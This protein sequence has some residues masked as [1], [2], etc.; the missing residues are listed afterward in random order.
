MKQD[1]DL[2]QQ[3]PRNDQN[4]I[5]IRLDQALVARGIVDTRAR[6]RDLILRGK[7]VVDGRQAPKASQTVRSGARVALVTGTVNYV[8]RGAEKLLAALDTFAFDARGRTALD[9]GSST[10]G[11]TEVLLATGAARVY[12]VD[13]GQGQLHDRLRHHPRVVL[14]EATD[15]RL[16]STI[17]IPD[18]ITALTADVSFISVTKALPAALA[19]AQPG[20][21]LI[22]LV[23][24]QFE[25]GPKAIGKGG[26]V[27]DANV[28]DAAVDSIRHWLAVDMGWTITGVIPSPIFGGD[29]NQEFLIGA[30]KP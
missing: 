30:I 1:Q 25:V 8:S 2:A 18:A 12:A 27:R 9:I 17:L 29:G 28:R 22:L 11:F 13:V 19:L 20:C 6:A 24:P 7:V 3:F 14:H 4:E 16:V 23:K 26:I 21:W 15:A 10:G 5:G